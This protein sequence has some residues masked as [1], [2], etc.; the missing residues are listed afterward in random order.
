MGFFNYEVIVSVKV[1]VVVLVMS[2]VVMY[3]EKSIRVN[4]VY[5]GFICLVLLVWF[6]GMLEVIECNS[7][8]NLMGVVG[9]GEDS[10][11]LIDLLFSD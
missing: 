7:K 11:V 4:C 9:E 5:L 2:M 6:I 10:V 1:V 3:V 8:M